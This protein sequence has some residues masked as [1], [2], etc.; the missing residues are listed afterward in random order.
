MQQIEPHPSLSGK[1]L[2]ARVTA[3]NPHGSASIFVESNCDPFVHEI[4]PNRYQWDQGWS[5]DDQTAQA[6]HIVSVLNQD[7]EISVFIGFPDPHRN[8]YDVENFQQTL[9]CSGGTAAESEEGN[10]SVV[11][12]ASALNGVVSSS[13]EINGQSV[14]VEETDIVSGGYRRV[15]LSF[16]IPQGTPS[17]ILTCHWGLGGWDDDPQQGFGD[18]YTYPLRING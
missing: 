14:A 10:Y 12:D 4:C 18:G 15:T 13:I 2:T 11:I 8:P 17:M 1:F 6:N 5:F 9:H 3:T 16:T 7:A